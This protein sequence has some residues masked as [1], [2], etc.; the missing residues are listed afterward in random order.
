MSQRPTRVSA[1][2]H[3]DQLVR[4]I[5]PLKKTGVLRNRSLS[6]WKD[7]LTAVGRWGLSITSLVEQSTVEFG[8]RT[9]IIDDFGELTFAELREQA[10]NMAINLALN[11]VKEGDMIAI[12]ARNSRGIILPL[13]AAGY[14]G[15]QPMIVNPA[16]STTQITNIFNAYG[17]DVF[18][19][20]AE[21]AEVAYANPDVPHYVVEGAVAAEGEEQVDIS[22]SPTIAELTSTPAQSFT[23]PKRP[24][25][26]NTVIMSSGTRGIP[27]GVVMPIPL[28][29]KALAG[30]TRVIPW[31]MNMTIQA[32][33]SIF[34]A[35]GYGN[36][37]AALITGST[38]I[39]RRHYDPVEAVA[40]CERYKVNAIISSAV[41]LRGFVAEAKKTGAK[42][43]PFE[44]IANSG[45]AVPAYLVEELVDAF[46][47]VLYSLYGS[48]EH[49]QISISTSEQMLADSSNAGR[50]NLGT[51]LKI[52]KEDGSEAG[53]GELG[54]I[55]SANSM[56][57]VGFLSDKYTPSTHDGLLATGDLGYLDEDGFLHLEGRAD[58]MVIKGGENVFP[59][60][61]EEYL[62]ALDEV[63][64]VYVSGKQ[65]D[66][67]AHLEAWVVK[68][69]S[70]TALTKDE[71]REKVRVAL[72]EHN[73]PEY[74]FWVDDLPRND[75]GKVVPRWLPDPATLDQDQS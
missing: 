29:P 42:I 37:L 4:S 65:D 7:T 75:S 38:Q 13:A 1:A 67:I 58:D 25:P 74:I 47:P 17:A 6:G 2:T 60:E 10:R 61:V 44:F 66:V 16:S 68:S 52:F 27:K 24:K 32:T 59:R 56:T 70:A 62:G 31:R 23:L 22:S 20:D 35:W 33:A 50:P 49:S 18:I 63:A 57:M 51:V 69:D 45:N 8:D 26:Q 15:A 71:L 39:L 9:A 30:V 5:K 72:A 19:V 40:D 43:G 54:E 55:Y 28:T 46:G 11:G 48:T 41:F 14:I 34:H 21:Y 12:Q 64:D 53:V 73:V 3:A 36:L